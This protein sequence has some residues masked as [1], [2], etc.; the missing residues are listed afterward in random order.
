MAET[1]GVRPLRHRGQE[2][3]GGAGMRILL[4]EVMLHFPHVIEPQAVGQFDL[5]KRLVKQA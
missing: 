4:E 2:H 5:V 1:D 3:L